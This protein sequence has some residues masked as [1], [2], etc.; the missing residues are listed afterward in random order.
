MLGSCPLNWKS[1]SVLVTGAGGFI[2]SHLAEALAR[3]GAKTRALIRYN[4][5]G[6]KGWLE[7]SDLKA[8]IEVIWGDI[9][10]ADSVKN[11]LRGVDVVF[12]LAA[13]IGIPYSYVSPS[14]YVSTNV[15]GTLNVLQECLRQGVSQ[16]VHTSTSEVYGTAQRIPITEDHPLHAQSPYSATKIAA[17]KL[18]ESFHRSFGLP[19]SIVRPF[20]TYGPRQSAR[21][22]IPTIMMQALANE[23]IRIGNLA[24]TRDFSYVSDTVRG[25]LH[26]AGSD[27]AIGRVVNLGAGKEIS[28]GD[29]AQM[30]CSLTGVE[31]RVVQEIDRVRPAQS[32]VERLCAGTILAEELTRWRPEVSLRE[33]LEKTL[34]WIRSNQANYQTEAYAI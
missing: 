1:K 7:Q 3:T 17:D 23:P 16:V 26:I 6:R 28:I 13:L 14:S 24:P 29:L 18:A 19:I 33:G 32:E 9:R 15:V 12:H 31:F 25:F 34:A 4:S 2:G 5:Q 27:K 30:I 21:A 20:N 8:D 10:E 22:V 11:A